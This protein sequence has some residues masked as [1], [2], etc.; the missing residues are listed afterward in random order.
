MKG[1][2]RIR[3]ILFTML[4]MLLLVTA[5][6]CRPSGGKD[7]T[8]TGIPTETTGDTTT[9]ATVES[10]TEI[11]TETSAETTTQPSTTQPPTTQS[12]TTGS[13]TPIIYVGQVLKIP[14][15][16]GAV[17]SSQVVSGGVIAADGKQI[18]LTFDA[19]WLYD[20]TEPLLNVLDAY[21]V[22]STF[23]LRG[24]WVSDHPQLAKEIAGR[25][26]EIENHSLTHSH[27][28][29]MTDVQILNEM[30]QSTDIILSTTGIRPHLFRP[31]FGEYDARMLPIL[32][33]EGYDYTVMWTV[34]SHDWAE[35]LN[36]VAITEAYLINRVLSNATD[37]GIVLMHVGGYHT[38]EALPEIITGLKNAGYSLVTVN[39]MLPASSGAD[40]YVLYTVVKGDTLYAISRR[41]GISVEEL[42][43]FNNLR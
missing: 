14:A 42:I 38:V 27:M 2:S 1:N 18:A 26:H 41:Y 36:G 33:A 39:D 10:S 5:S 23:F 31:P 32:G 8:T 13:L 15:S 22:K 24:Y 20:Q 19:G 28:T 9:E 6:S 34:D 25:G 43:E 11:T 29:A 7:G 4:L 40:G 16:G 17:T 3:K 12:P 35:E 30:V 21:D 37:N